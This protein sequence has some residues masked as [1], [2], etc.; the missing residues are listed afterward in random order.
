V[1]IS[2]GINTYKPYNELTSR[3]QR[4]IH[5]LRINAPASV[6]LYNIDRE[7]NSYKRFKHLQLER[8]SKDIVPN[9][10]K[11][12]A[13][14]KDIFNLLS[15]TD[16]DYFAYLND[17]ITV[18]LRVFSTIRNE[19]RDCFIISRIDTTEVKNLKDVP[20]NLSCNLHGF[21]MFIIKKSW[22]LE[23]KKYFPNFVL[24]RYYWDTYYY[25]LCHIFGNTLTLNDQ[26]YIFHPAHEN[27]S[28]IQ[29]AETMYNTSLLQDSIMSLWYSNVQLNFKNRASEHNI[30]D[31]KPTINEKEIERQIFK[32]FYEKNFSNIC[33]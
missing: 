32:T 7:A 23:N 31:L 26:P 22:W 9:S 14:S 1:K 4:C 28:N 10:T 5:F 16:C 24:G 20:Q 18:G 25:C 8:T 15:Q 29:D 2:I 12:L 30:K 21:D 13:M 27:V 33:R 19:D 6:S 3:Q 11:E 17:D